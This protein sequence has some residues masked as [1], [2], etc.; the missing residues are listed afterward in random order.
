MKQDFIIL[1]VERRKN[2]KNKLILKNA[3]S[4]NKKVAQ[5]SQGLLTDLHS[6][7]MFDLLTKW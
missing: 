6:Q 7:S 5:L 1:I 3:V 4:R 2:K